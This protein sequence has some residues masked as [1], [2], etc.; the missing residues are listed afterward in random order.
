MKCVTD[1]SHD[2]GT[3]WTLNR[4]G[5]VARCGLFT[6][7]DGWELRVF[8][9][10]QPL[11]WKRCRATE[12]VSMVADDWKERMLEDGWALAPTT[13]PVALRRRSPFSSFD[14]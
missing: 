14:R 1:P 13:R 5:A 8:V 6:S 7:R 9:N 2:L 3:C 11:L 12:D 10:E 4:A